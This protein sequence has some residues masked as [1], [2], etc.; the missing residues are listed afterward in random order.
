MASLSRR[1]LLATAMAAPV[2]TMARVDPV[3]KDRL[4]IKAGSITP[5]IYSF[6]SGKLYMG[7]RFVGD[8]TDVVISS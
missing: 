2:I 8:V 3:V 7:D 4:M 5:V 1:K 6:G